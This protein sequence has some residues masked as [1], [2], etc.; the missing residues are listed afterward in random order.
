ML[1]DPQYSYKSNQI[2]YSFADGNT[3]DDGLNP[4][5]KK[6][7]NTQYVIYIGISSNS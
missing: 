3:F 1:L 6:E 7:N 2:A 4:L 5:I